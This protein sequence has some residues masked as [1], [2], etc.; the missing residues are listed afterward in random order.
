MP[1]ST[2]ETGVTFAQ[3]RQALSMRQANAPHER[4]KN[5][6]RILQLLNEM[7]VPAQ[8]WFKADGTA[9]AVG[10]TNLQHPVLREAAPSAHGEFQTMTKR[11]HILAKIENT[12]T[13]IN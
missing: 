5:R 7:A 1:A 8:P 11:K 10:S 9:T 2:K 12:L 4:W 13:S 6:Q 3:S